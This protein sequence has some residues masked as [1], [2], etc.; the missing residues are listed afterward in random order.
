M[1]EEKLVKSQL[2][3]EGKI[4]NLRRDEVELPNGR[5]ATR[6]IVVHNGAVAMLPVLPDGRIIFVEQFRQATGHVLLEIPAGKIEAGEDIHTCL[7]R[8]LL[9]E[10]GYRANKFEKLISFYPAPGYSTEVI[11]IYR[12]TELEECTPQPDEDEFIR[13][14]LLDLEDALKLVLNNTI[15]DSKT[16]IAILLEHYRR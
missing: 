4:L 9:E 7:E 13:V 3:Y 15:E 8:E 11:H 12:A 2:L 14:K 6:E 1:L 10:T 16:I 5:H